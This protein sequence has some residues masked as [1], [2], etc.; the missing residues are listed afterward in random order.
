VI[1]AQRRWATLASYPER[2]TGYTWRRFTVIEPSRPLT[3]YTSR[4]VAMPAD[5]AA[6]ALAVLGD[7]GRVTIRT[8]DG[9]LDLGVPL[10]SPA[11]AT[12][13]LPRVLTGRLRGHGV[14]GRLCATG[15]EVEILAWSADETELGLRPRRLR[16][17]GTDRYFSRA[18]EALAALA[19][20]VV[21]ASATAPVGTH[22]EFAVPLRRAS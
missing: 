20:A 12:I 5:E 16:S 4:R 11:V 1:P 7:A 9:A 13:G 8:Q 22:S 14:L 17:F 21:D 15:V 3:W 19:A 18:H 6:R 2:N 10:D